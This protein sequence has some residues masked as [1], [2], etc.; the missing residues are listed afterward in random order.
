MACEIKS[1][2]EVE[3]A[4]W[5]EAKKGLAAGLEPEEVINQIAKTHGIGTDAVGAVLQSRQMFQL[6]NEA[7]AKQAKLAELRTAA[8]NEV[9]IADKPAWLKALNKPIHSKIPISRN[10]Y[11][12]ARQ[13]LTIGHGGVIPFTHARTSL[14][15]PGEQAIFART[16]GRAY[17]YATPKAGSARWRADM[18]KLRTDPAFNFAARAGLDIKLQSKPVGMGMSRWTRQ[19][20]DALKTMRLELFKK[21]REQL[22]DKSFEAA[23]D[24]AKRINHATGTVATPPVVSKIA[25]ATMFA[26]KLRFAKYASAVD[27]FTSKFGAKRFAKVAAVNLGILGIN[28]A[29]NRYVLQNND[30]VNWNDPARA[31]WLRLKIG[32]MTL[33]MSP[34]FETM[35]LPVAAG[36]VMMD[37]REDNKAKV[38]TKE[39]ASAVHPGI[40]A[41]YGGVTGKDLATG[42]A[43][44]FKG[45]SQYI[46]G[47]HRN[48]RPMFGKMV[49][50]KHAQKISGGEYASGYLPIPA[51]PIVKELVKEGITPHI[52]ESFVEALLSG[53]AGTHAYPN[54]PYKTKKPLKN[55]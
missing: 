21:Y 10:P 53:A 1:D 19:S 15:V 29:F 42:K 39:L 52:A 8:K 50:D 32:G 26:P 20:F 27:A 51:Q 22:P 38:L 47:E 40:N 37:P 17:S 25:G 43:L 4:F 30:K 5:N 55:Q 7:W 54:V 14:L 3:K 2:P 36:A 23:K 28:D 48:E 41:I 31:D 35:R 34:L 9:R 6:T 45:A 12:A 49:K 16:V 24:L 44:P 33:P 11:E 13:T 46:Y 18:A